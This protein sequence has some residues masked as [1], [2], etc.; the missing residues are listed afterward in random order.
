MFN[1]SI[2]FVVS[3]IEKSPLVNDNGILYQRYKNFF[4]AFILEKL[5]FDNDAVLYENLETQE[6]KSR[7]KLSSTEL[8]IKELTVFFMNKHIKSALENIYKTVLKFSS[9]DIWIDNT[10]Y[11]LPPHIDDTRI[12][13]GLQIYCSNVPS[14]GTTF[15]SKDVQDVVD[16]KIWKDE[17]MKYEVDTI[18]FENNCGYS[19]LNNRLSYHGVYPTKYDSR[20]SLYVRFK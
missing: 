12:K 9:C 16:L 1:D 18:M 8:V 11:W 7:K 6:Y 2:K 15:F 3:S 4:D 17:Y 5:N 20:K 19:L 13:L 14:S 10:G